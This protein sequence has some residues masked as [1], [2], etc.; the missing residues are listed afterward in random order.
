MLTDGTSHRVHGHSNQDILASAHAGLG[1]EGR[2]NLGSLFHV[3]LKLGADGLVNS[4]SAE[5]S[6]GSQIFQSSG[7]VGYG[8][9]GLGLHF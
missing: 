7:I 3:A 6:D 9:L 2:Y 5:R 4:V 1:F 8:M